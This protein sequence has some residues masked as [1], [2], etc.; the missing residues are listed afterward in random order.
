M[1]FLTELSSPAFQN[2]SNHYMW[3]QLFIRTSC[4]FGWLFS[5]GIMLFSDQ[6]AVLIG[7][8]R[9][10]NRIIWSNGTCY[11]NCPPFSVLITDPHTQVF[12]ADLLSHSGSPTSLERWASYFKFLT[13]IFLLG[14]MNIIISTHW[15]NVKT[16]CV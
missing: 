13:L 5:P 11:I 14:G 1:R 8:S 9:L 4:L 12:H 6:S 15:G 7:F 2:K 3:G 10:F 16:K